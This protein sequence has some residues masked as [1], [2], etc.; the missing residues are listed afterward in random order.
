MKHVDG[1]LVI[2]GTEKSVLWRGRI[3]ATRAAEATSA[4]ESVGRGRAEH[5]HGK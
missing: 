1:E 3:P 4:R 2:A 5:N